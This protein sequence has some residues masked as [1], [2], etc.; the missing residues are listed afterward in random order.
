MHELTPML[1]SNVS[2]IFKGA[3]VGLLGLGVI[4]LLGFQNALAQ[5]PPEI[6]GL[7]V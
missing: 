3:G 2:R 6:A 5:I 1:A 4:G 7:A